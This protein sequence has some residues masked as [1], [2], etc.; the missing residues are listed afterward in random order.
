MLMLLLMLIGMSYR[1][2]CRLN[3]L[4]IHYIDRK[5]LN[6]SKAFCSWPNIADGCTKA[7]NFCKAIKN[8]AVEYKSWIVL[9]IR[10]LV[11]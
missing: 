8:K 2:V 6:V 3:V 7:M 1:Y 5:L 11:G 10:Y 9:H 4:I